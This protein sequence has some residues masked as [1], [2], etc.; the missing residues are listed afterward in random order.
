M[1]GLEALPSAMM[2][3]SAAIAS[4]SPVATGR[5]RPEASGSPSSM[6]SSTVPETKPVASSPRNSRGERSTRSA[7]PSSSACSS[8]STRA[9]ISLW[10]RR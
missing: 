9:G 1:I 7:M 8:S 10:V 2:T 3:R 4:V 5:R 6:T